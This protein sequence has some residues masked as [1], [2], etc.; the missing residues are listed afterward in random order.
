MN[1]VD[2]KYDI[3]IK[4]F[5]YEFIKQFFEFCNTNLG[6]DTRRLNNEK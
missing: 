5:F 4:L 6:G 2:T 3:E 1:N